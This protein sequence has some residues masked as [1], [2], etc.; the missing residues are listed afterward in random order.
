MPLYEYLCQNCNKQVELL[1]QGEER[2]VCPECS[3]D[4]LTKLLSV[5]AAHSREGA[6]AAPSSGGGRPCGAHC[7]CHPHG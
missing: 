4:R 2:P 7:G 5:V 1:V 6:G 3:G